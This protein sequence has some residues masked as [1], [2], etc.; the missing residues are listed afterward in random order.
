MH[1]NFSLS[2]SAARR[3]IELRE[4]E[5]KPGLMIRI[6][7]DG[8]GCSGFQYRFDFAE[9]A[10]DDDR[11]FER[12]GAVV[13]IDEVSLDLLAGGELNFVEEMMGRYFEVRNPNAQSSC[14][15]GSSFAL[16]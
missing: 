10:N 4:H 2:E 14:G 15:C 16:A 3:I 9:A 5:K 6:A 13:V 12:D 7:V 11:L 8:G 1:Q